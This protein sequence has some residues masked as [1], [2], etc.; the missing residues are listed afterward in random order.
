MLIHQGGEVLGDVF[1]PVAVPIPPYMR[2]TQEVEGEGIR[3]E[4]SLAAHQLAI[5]RR[6][7]KAEGIV[8]AHVIGAPDGPGKPRH[9][10]AFLVDEEGTPALGSSA[11]LQG[12]RPPE[13]GHFI[14]THTAGPLDTLW[15]GDRL[16]G[17]DELL[18]VGA[19]GAGLALFEL[20][21][22]LDGAAGLG[23]RFVQDIAG[24]G[25]AQG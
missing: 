1:R 17:L 7:V 24:Q 16:A 3:G 11:V 21:I 23:R 6:I 20:R 8:E 13:G 22:G 18:P 9:P 12:F 14:L 10:L 15:P 25:G 5:L 2:G 19:E 4:K